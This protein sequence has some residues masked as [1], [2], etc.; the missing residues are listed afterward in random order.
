MSGQAKQ[1]SQFF[2]GLLL[3]RTRIQA[4][5]QQASGRT[6]EAVH[7]VDDLPRDAVDAPNGR[8]GELVEG[9]GREI[10]VAVGTCLAAIHQL[11]LDRL[12]LVCD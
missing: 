7:L 4:Y 9:V 2:H 12:A 1:G 8:V 10:E 6:R 5:T 3:V 11:H